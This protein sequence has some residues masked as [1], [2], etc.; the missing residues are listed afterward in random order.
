M[1]R[2]PRG[3]LSEQLR[4]FVAATPVEREPILAFV[5]EVARTVPAGSTVLDVG[6]GDAPYRELFAHTDYTTVDWGQSLHDGGQGGT[7]LTASADAIPLP[8]LTADLI[9]L[10]QV[11]EHVPRP[12]AV[13]QE[14]HRLLRDGGRLVVTVPMTWE[15]HE[16]PHDYFRYTAAGLRA[17]L[18]Q[19]GFRVLR[20]TGRGGALESVAQLLRNLSWQLGSRPEDRLDDLRAD[21]GPF[22]RSLADHLVQ[23][24]PLATADILPL[25][26]QAEAVKVT[27]P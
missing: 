7:D 3:G 1:S 27:V 10:T 4:D 13:L 12:L 5:H 21:A 25:G 18:E 15:L 20:V 14:Q 22:L 26:F 9:M 24:Q 16:Q 2:D 11:L 8:A 23:M 17:V 19:T 6:A